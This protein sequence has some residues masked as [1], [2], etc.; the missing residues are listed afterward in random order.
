MIQ[1]KKEKEKEAYRRRIRRTLFWRR[2]G[3]AI[4]I[5]LMVGLAVASLF[6]AMLWR[7]HADKKERERAAAVLSQMPKGDAFSVSPILLEPSMLPAYAG[8]DYVT[9][10]ENVPGFNLYDLQHF[11]GESYSPLDA[12]GRCG[13]AM[14]LLHRSMMPK[15]ERGEIGDVKP[16]GWV[17]KKYEGVVESTPPYLYNRCHLIA[18]AL[19]GQ[20][21]NEKNLITGT[22]HFNADAMLYFEIQVMEYLEHN[23]AHVLY[24][25]TPYFQ[26][27]ELLARG[28]EMEAYSVEDGG[29]GLCF[30]VF[31]YNTQPG[32]TLDYATG[33]S[34]AD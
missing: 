21:A 9:L 16:T 27:T 24:R 1:G 33:E 5:S 20:N 32:I 22:R 4:T 23:D 15:E 2:Y 7:A 6:V 10:N 12:L 18:Y 14:A 11:T 3:N 8:E 17:Q 26:G 25:V 30:H 28:V 31:V 29:R 34:H 13:P 19:T